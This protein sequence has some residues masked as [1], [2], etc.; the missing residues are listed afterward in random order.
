MVCVTCRRFMRPKKNGVYI[1]EL[2]P[3]NKDT[4]EDPARESW[5]PYKLWAADLY[6]CPQ[7]KVQM[8]GGFGG[9]PVS[10]HYRDGYAELR[11]R[12]G[13]FLQVPD[14][15]P[16]H[17]GP[18]PLTN[19]LAK[20]EHL[21]NFHRASLR[22]IMSLPIIEKHQAVL[23]PNAPVSMNIQECIDREHDAL[24]GQV[25]NMQIVEAERLARL[26]DAE[27]LAH[28]R[29]QALRANAEW[30]G[31]D[32]NLPCWC[33]GYERPTETHVARCQQARVTMVAK[34]GT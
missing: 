12:L 26:M 3:G 10:E 13:V 28:A 8:V 19:A 24:E 21:L 33:D 25:R 17:A 29:G 9:L 31:D 16:A 1:E 6:E 22:D 27:R 2:A 32:D 7:C 14:C 30:P 23:D 5:W 20:A 15:G 4:I 11:E 34:A 18:G